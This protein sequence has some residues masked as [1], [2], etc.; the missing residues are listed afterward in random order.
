MSAA[1]YRLA[2]FSRNAMPGDIEEMK[3]EVQHVLVSAR[4]NNEAAN[5]TGALLFN[6]SCFAQVLE[7]P[8]AAIEST[9][10]RI[11][12]DP[13]HSDVTVLELAPVELREFPNWSMA[14]AG[15]L[16]ESRANFVSFTQA[17]V[18]HNEG[19]AEALYNLLHDLVLREEG[20]A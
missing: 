6:E 4:R 1:L 15:L 11:Q 16:E 3:R 5:I 2:Y 9:F 17:R 19:S 8:L 20:R 12:R 14:F 7:G 10:E 18:R 13:R